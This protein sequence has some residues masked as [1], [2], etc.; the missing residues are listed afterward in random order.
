[1]RSAI[2]HRSALTVRRVIQNVPISSAR[3]IYAGDTTHVI[4]KG[5]SLKTPGT[6]NANATKSSAAAMPST[7]VAKMKTVRMT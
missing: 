4:H 3:A 6:G 1:V 2:D 5:A 7:L